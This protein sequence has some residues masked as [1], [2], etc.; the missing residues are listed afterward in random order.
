MVVVRSRAASSRPWVIRPQTVRLGLLPLFVTPPTLLAPAFLPL[1]F[2]PGPSA[3]SALPRY[4]RSVPPLSLRFADSAQSGAATPFTPA[5]TALSEQRAAPSRFAT[6]V[7][8]VAAD[9]RPGVAVAPPAAR[10]HSA[11]FQSPDP[12]RLLHCPDHNAQ[13]PKPTP[14]RRDAV[15]RFR[16][17]QAGCS[18]SAADSPNQ[19]ATRPPLAPVALN[20]RRRLALAGLKRRTA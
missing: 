8:V 9:P 12:H 20:A 2:A 3:I 4:V 17:R 5:V 18:P 10:Q 15:T 1:R 11:P 19:P 7:A 13:G 6:G 16:A 14:A